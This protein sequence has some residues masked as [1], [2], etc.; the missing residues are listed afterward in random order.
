[1]AHP[2]RQHLGL[3]IPA[4]LPERLQAGRGGLIVEQGSESLLRIGDFGFA[5]LPF[6][7]ASGNLFP[8]VLDREESL[9]IPGPLLKRSHQIE[10]LVNHLLELLCSLLVVA[11]VV[12]DQVVLF[13]YRIILGLRL[14][15]GNMHP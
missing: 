13:G 14:R 6:F 8:N 3:H 10:Q 4:H 5:R 11:T 2:Q 15:S 9:L 1:M 7:R 12:E